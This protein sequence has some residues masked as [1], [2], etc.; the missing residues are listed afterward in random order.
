MSFGDDFVLT[1]FTN[2][3]ALA[4]R[5]DRA[6]VNRIG[7]DIERIGKSNRQ[8][9]LPTWIS[10][11]REEELL[12]LR[13]V[14]QQAA[15]FARCTPMHP[16]SK[17]EVDR[18]LGLGGQV[19]MLP[20]FVTVQAPEHFIRYGVGRSRPWS[21]LETASATAWKRNG[22]LSGGAEPV[23]MIVP[24]CSPRGRSAGG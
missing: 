16:A 2:D 20:Y 5:A 9:H 24:W 3:L 18:L 7:V 23:M 15:L 8:G 4:A 22:T 6:G 12:G 21:L 17:D 1:L 14:L 19:H 13:G 10:D 11:H